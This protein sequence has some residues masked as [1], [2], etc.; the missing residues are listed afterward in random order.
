[1]VG[2][3]ALA[4]QGLPV[5]KL[6]LTRE[7]EDQL[8]DLAGN[9]MSTTVVGACIL[10]ALVVGKKL[11]KEG[12]DTETYEY[13]NSQD[14]NPELMQVDSTGVIEAHTDNVV[15]AEELRHKPLKLSGKQ[16]YDLSSILTDAENSSR[17]CG[18]EG[19]TD[20]VDRD[21]LRCVDCSSTFC[22]KCGGR[23]EHNPQPMKFD[24]NPRL[25]PADF[26]KTLKTILPMCL[27]LTGVTADL[28]EKLK[29]QE[30]LPIVKGR[31]AKWTEA[32]LRGSASELRFVEC[33][34]QEI[35]TVVYQSSHAK[36]ELSLHPQR[37]EWRFF[38]FPDPSEPARAEIRQVLAAP[39]GRLICGDN[40]LSGRWYFALP[41]T[42]TVPIQIQGEGELVP[43]WEARLGLTREDLRDKVVYPHLKVAIPKDQLDRFDRDI[44]GTY[45]LLEKCGTAN[46]ALHKKQGQDGNLPALYMLLDP[47]RTKDSED[48]FV[49]SANIRRLEY[50]ES[51]PIVCKLDPKWRQSSAEG[52][53][54]VA[55]HIPCRWVRSNAV[56]LQV[57][58]ASLICT[59]ALSNLVYRLSLDIAQ[60]SGHPTPFKS[61]IVLMLVRTHMRFS[62]VRWTYVVRQERNGPGENGGR[63]IRFTKEE[64]SRLSRGSLNA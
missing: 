16:E 32:V 37:P 50:G 33:K 35:W 31:W 47:H 23:P 18:C 9:A 26:T 59:A 17:L 6:L 27:S 46:G 14:Y 10:A 28:L 2:L 53:Q 41:H 63:L 58:L 11:L 57:C 64:H 49:F 55:C 19:R 3:E 61:P 39:I 5:D 52:E 34:R 60:S 20:M 24:Q 40:L 21:L 22:V 45:T 51:R 1:M 29:D 4:M 7:S 48:A 56:T 54:T 38:V 12:G 36:L 15:G 42:T 8:A 30:D 13:K 62:R 44:T 43:S 25:H